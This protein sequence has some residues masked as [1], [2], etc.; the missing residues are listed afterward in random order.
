MVGPKKANI[1]LL[2]CL[3]GE[4]VAKTVEIVLFL[5]LRQGTTRIERTCP[6]ESNSGVLGP[7]LYTGFLAAFKI[8]IHICSHKHLLSAWTSLRDW[9][10]FLFPESFL[11][12]LADEIVL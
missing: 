6:E 10:I 9:R 8:I 3:W 7:T 4:N 5:G 12:A 11:P 2:W 1:D